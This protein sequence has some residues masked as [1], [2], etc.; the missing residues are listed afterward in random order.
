M[1]LLAARSRK[2]FGQTLVDLFKV[3]RPKIWIEVLLVALDSATEL[4]KPEQLIDAELLKRDV[5]PV[6]QRFEC[7]AGLG[8]HCRSQVLSNVDEG[9]SG[10]FTGD[11]RATQSGSPVH[12][13]SPIDPA[14]NGFANRTDVLLREAGGD[15][16]LKVHRLLCVE[17]QDVGVDVE[18]AEAPG[19]LLLVDRLGVV[20]QKF[21]ACVPAFGGA[22]RSR[23]T[24]RIERPGSLNAVT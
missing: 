12:V 5:E 9:A 17:A 14:R 24:L 4:K 13:P 18:E 6:A 22:L 2:P 20:K 1:R 19:L 10:S 21:A 7:P 11:F 16:A 15:Q 3:N 23:A 8:D